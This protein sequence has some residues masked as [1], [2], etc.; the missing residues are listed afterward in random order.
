MPSS[1]PLTAKGPKRDV[2]RLEALCKPRPQPNA[3]NRGILERWNNA[4]LGNESATSPSFQYSNIPSFQCSPPAEPGQEIQV[5][6]QEPHL[7]QKRRPAAG[8]RETLVV[9]RGNSSTTRDVA[10]QLSPDIRPGIQGILHD[11]AGHIAKVSQFD[12][13]R[14]RPGECL[15]LVTFKPNQ[16]HALAHV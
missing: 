6:P 16:S 12:L 3:L 8:W 11:I 4:M 15:R 13:R 10:F 5:L 7:L 2:S 14:C 1:L 9:L